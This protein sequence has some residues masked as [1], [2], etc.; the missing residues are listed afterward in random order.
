M[1]IEKVHVN[2]AFECH[3]AVSICV[4]DVCATPHI[5]G[6]LPVC[7]LPLPIRYEMLVAS[8]SSGHRLE[9]MREGSP[10]CQNI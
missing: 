2:I 6:T 9:D 8:V 10:E 7:L 1:T 5:R 4:R 3:A